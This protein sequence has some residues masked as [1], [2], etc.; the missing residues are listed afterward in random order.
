MNQYKKG[1]HIKIVQCYNFDII[2]MSKIHFDNSFDI[3]IFILSWK[4]SW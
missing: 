4:S 3:Y 1:E 2:Q